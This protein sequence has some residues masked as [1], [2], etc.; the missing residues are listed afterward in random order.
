MNIEIYGIEGRTFVDVKLSGNG[1]VSL[2]EI[3]TDGPGMNCVATVK[4]YEAGVDELIL[5]LQEVKESF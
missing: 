4:L 1:L 2:V 5:A 3:F